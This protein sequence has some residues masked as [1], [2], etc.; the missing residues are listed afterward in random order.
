MIK[1]CLFALLAVLL[2]AVVGFFILLQVKKPNFILYVSN[3]S[4][5]QT[6]VDITIHIDGKRV[7]SSMFEVRNQHHRIKYRFKLTS[8]THNLVA[9]SVKGE[10]KIERD[11]EIKDKKHWAE[12]DYWYSPE[13]GEEK[14][15]LFQIQ[16]KQIFIM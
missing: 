6:P 14:I 8:G 9:V 7:I 16:N 12:I 5:A 4:F 2:L 1:K 15:F 3:Q 13:Q 10:A 11:F